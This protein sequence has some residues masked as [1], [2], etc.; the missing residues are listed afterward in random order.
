MPYALGILYNPIQVERVGFHSAK[1]ANPPPILREIKYNAAG[2]NL[3]PSIYMWPHTDMSIQPGDSS[4]TRFFYTVP[5][6]LILAGM[7]FA[8]FVTSGVQAGEWGPYESEGTVLSI[9]VDQ[10]L[11]LLD[12][13]PIRAPGYLMGKMEMPFS[14]AEPAL[15]NGLK[16]GDRIHFRVSE[17]KKSRIVEIRKLPK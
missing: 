1:P 9:L 5:K 8:I 4:M 17:E 10:G 3:R 2:Q 7:L 13:E 16:A 12:H 6:T 15:I 14:V 11:I